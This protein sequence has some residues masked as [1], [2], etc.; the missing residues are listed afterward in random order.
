MTD[1]IRYRHTVALPY[2]VFDVSSSHD[3]FEID[4]GILHTISQINKIPKVD[5]CAAKEEKKQ[6]HTRSQNAGQVNK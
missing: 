1:R 5:K 4:G 6:I 2:E 3:V